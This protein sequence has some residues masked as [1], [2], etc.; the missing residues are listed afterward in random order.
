MNARVEVPSGLS[1]HRKRRDPCPSFLHYC[2][3]GA[4]LTISRDASYLSR[5]IRSF[6]DK[7]TKTLFEGRPAA[8][9]RRIAGV[10][11][12]KMDMLDAAASLGDLRSPPGNRLEALRGDRPGQH[13]DPDQ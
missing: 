8:R 1:G 5:V 11:A 6:R 12:R 10:A 3:P 13:S 7:A 4:T 9:L 2:A